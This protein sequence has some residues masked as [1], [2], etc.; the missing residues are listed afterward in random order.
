[1]NSSISHTFLKETSIIKAET[2]TELGI[3]SDDPTTGTKTA[4]VCTATTV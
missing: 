1:M 4:I 2:I 3:V